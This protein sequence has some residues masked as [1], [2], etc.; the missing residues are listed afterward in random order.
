M[1]RYTYKCSGCGRVFDI[2][3]PYKEIRKLCIDEDCDGSVEKVLSKPISYQSRSP[4][5]T[6]AAGS[7][8]KETIAETK[9]ELKNFKRSR[10][11]YKK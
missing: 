3:H 8:I 10:K 2:T 1:P 4:A 6:Q 11:I 9:E 7:V 5:Q